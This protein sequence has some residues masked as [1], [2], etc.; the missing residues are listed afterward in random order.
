MTANTNKRIESNNPSATQGRKVDGNNCSARPESYVDNHRLSQIGVAVPM[1]EHTGGFMDPR[2][3][4]SCGAYLYMLPGYEPLKY[5][6][7]DPSDLD[8]DLA[9]WTGKP[10]EDPPINKATATS[11]SQAFETGNQG[12]EKTLP[13]SGTTSSSSRDTGKTMRGSGDIPL[14]P[15]A[16]NSPGKFLNMSTADRSHDISSQ[17]A[18]PPGSYGSVEHS[19]FA[20]A[21]SK[22]HGR[23]L[24][25]P[26]VGS[27]SRR[28]ASV[29][30]TTKTYGKAPSN[31]FTTSTSSSGAGE[32]SNGVWEGPYDFNVLI[33]TLETIVL[34]ANA[35]VNCFLRPILTRLEPEMVKELEDSHLYVK[36]KDV[37]SF[38]GRPPLGKAAQEAIRA[39]VPP[40]RQVFVNLLAAILIAQDTLSIL[41]EKAIRDANGPARFVE[42]PATGRGK[43]RALAFVGTLEKIDEGLGVVC[44][45]AMKNIWGSCS[46][47]TMEVLHGTAL[48]A[49]RA[50]LRC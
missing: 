18:F 25:T 38:Q 33:N 36:N 23:T 14:A 45:E 10:T 40:N 9:R 20:D 4:C 26:V 29:V 19:H 7:G 43:A 8:L 13:T 5:L 22:S 15:L 35:R 46:T 31:P 49:V 1:D 24:S 3:R 41:Q 30:K 28:V 42:R 44:L 47:D 6:R 50:A 32:A 48:A 12:R 37:V 21:P 16:S 11:S 27:S 2:S 34:Y 17:S 39:L